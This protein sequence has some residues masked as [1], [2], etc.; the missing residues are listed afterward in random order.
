MKTAKTK[1]A[2]MFGTS[3]QAQVMD[4]LLTHDSCYEIVAF[5]SSAEF[6]IEPTIY[7]RPLVPFETIESVYPPA[8]YEMHIAIGYN[9]Q[10]TIRRKFYDAAKAKG[11]RLL[12]YISSR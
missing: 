7:G 4:Y 12:T 10:N 1:K 9:T 11:Y 2:I 3:G 8:E 5:T 6:V